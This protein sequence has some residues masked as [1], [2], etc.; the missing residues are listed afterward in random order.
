VG[1]GVCGPSYEHHR[2]G[3]AVP[4]DYFLAVPFAQPFRP[5]KSFRP[6]FAALEAPPLQNSRTSQ[7]AA[8]ERSR[9]AS[10]WLRTKLASSN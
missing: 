5:Q 1:D 2:T 3:E 9:G 8:P 7:L 10:G 4:K 6:L